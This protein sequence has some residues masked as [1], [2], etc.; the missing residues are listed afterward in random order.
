MTHDIAVAADSVRVPLS[1]H[2]VADI[3]RAVLRSER[4]RATHLSITFVSVRRIAAMNARHLGHH[5]ST[6]VIS[7]V[8]APERAGGPVSGDVYIAPDIARR[9]AREHGASVREELTRLVIHGVLH[10]LGYDHPE[11]E[12]RVSSRM[13]Q[14]QEVL[15]A[16]LVKRA[17]RRRAGPRPTSSAA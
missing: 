9:N 15:V 11:E 14:R 2:R 10:V 4:A 5:G 8:F 12:G 17:S 3:A 16:A 13:W 6:D 1:R 7:F